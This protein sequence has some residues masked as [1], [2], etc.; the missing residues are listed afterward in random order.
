MANEYGSRPRLAGQH[1][2]FR[3]RTELGIPVVHMAMLAP[4]N[5]KRTV[6]LINHSRHDLLHLWADGTRWMAPAYNNR[7]VDSC[8]I[9]V[10]YEIGSEVEFHLAPFL[11]DDQEV[12]KQLDEIGK[13]ID[14]ARSDPH[15]PAV[16][17]PVSAVVEF[18]YIVDLTDIEL[19][20]DGLYIEDL[21]VHIFN[22]DK[23]N[24]NKVHYGRRGYRVSN[25]TATATEEL[26]QLKG[27]P[28]SA[29]CS[30]VYRV[31]RRDTR[32]VYVALDGYNGKLVPVVDRDYAPGIYITSTR[33][34]DLEGTLITEEKFYPVSDFSKLNVFDN[35]D[36]MMVWSQAQAKKL[37]AN[38][39][40]EELK[41]FAE[42]QPELLR[43]FIME[44]EAQRRQQKADSKK[45]NSQQREEDPYDDPLVIFRDVMTVVAAVLPLVKSIWN[46]FISKDKDAGAN[47]SV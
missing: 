28:Q 10:T 12:N 42:S 30:A 46:G 21:G 18:S 37:N 32:S 44:N 40:R 36:E 15:Y 23:R 6:E 33:Y 38:P 35:I 26:N 39:T 45:Q 11:E 43:D 27:V 31:H 14:A 34:V 25:V 1:K 47:S 9:L 16:R 24:F 41:D 29:G 8:T 3:T 19:T 22:A 17:R 5:M 20:P 4:G 13:R 7:P 2:D